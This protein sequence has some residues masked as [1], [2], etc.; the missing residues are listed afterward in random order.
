MPYV[1][2]SVGFNGARP[3]SDDVL[4]KLCRDFNAA[5][6]AEHFDNLTAPIHWAEEWWDTAMQRYG[7]ESV[8]QVLSITHKVRVTLRLNSAGEV[9]RMFKEAAER[10]SKNRGA[11]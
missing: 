11:I 10:Y 2:E 8:V 1:L 7:A 6:A 3:F 5:I 9:M 4:R